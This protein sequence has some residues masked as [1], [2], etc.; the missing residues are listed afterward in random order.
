M[1]VD[2]P[3]V[4]SEKVRKAHRQHKCCECQGIIKMGEN[5]HLDK[6]CW[7]GKWAEFKTCMECDDLRHEPHSLYRDDEGPAYGEL[8]EW[9]N[10]A[11][12]SIVRT[13]FR[14]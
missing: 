11:G 6:G 9:A 14:R 13:I 5:Y 12:I 3:S 8:R 10:E 2:F 4:F 1:S 7:D